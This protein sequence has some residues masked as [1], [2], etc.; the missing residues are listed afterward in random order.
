L[1]AGRGARGGDEECDADVGK[2]SGARGMRRGRGIGGGAGSRAGSEGRGRGV[3]RGAAAAGATAQATAAL[4]KRSRR[5]HGSVDNASAQLTAAGT[6]KAQHTSSAVAAAA[7]ASVTSAGILS[8]KTAAALSKG[9]LWPLPLLLPGGGLLPSTTLA[10]QPQPLL[11]H[12]LDPKPEATNS[13]LTHPGLAMFSPP[14]AARGLGAP[15]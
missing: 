2:S 12:F 6:A 13:Q 14:P 15:T 4:A 10:G 9:P 1:A 11:N 3:K 8:P 7:A 5:E